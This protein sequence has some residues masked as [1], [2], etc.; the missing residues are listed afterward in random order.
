[1]FLFKAN[2]ANS[3]AWYAAVW[4]ITASLENG[5]AKLFVDL[6][7]AGISTLGVEWWECFGMPTAPLKACFNSCALEW[8]AGDI[9]LINPIITPNTFDHFAI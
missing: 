9:D 5:W 6:A 2:L 4:L 7:T 1:M 8:S 3:G